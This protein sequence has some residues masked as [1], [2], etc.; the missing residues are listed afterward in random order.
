MGGE[1]LL[2]VKRFKYDD[3]PLVLGER[4]LQRVEFSNNTN[5]FQLPMI[6]DALDLIK[7]FL[8]I[9]NSE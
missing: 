6:N 3:G 9:K 4:F 2:S 5:H 7:I 1:W 8:L